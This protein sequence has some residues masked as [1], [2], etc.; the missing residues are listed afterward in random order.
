M[1]FDVLKVAS[2]FATLEA[3][4]INRRGDVSLSANMELR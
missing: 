4:T 3:E 1:H 2:P